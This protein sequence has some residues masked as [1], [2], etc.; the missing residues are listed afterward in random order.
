MAFTFPNPNT[1]TEFDAPNGITYSWDSVDGKWVV[2]GFGDDSPDP[3]YVSKTGGDSMEG[4][5]R[6]SGGRDA[7][8]DGI[9]SSVKALNIDSGQI[10]SL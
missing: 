7:D 8:S 3:R 10:S 6:V 5:L 4:P 1:T 2:K 9:Q